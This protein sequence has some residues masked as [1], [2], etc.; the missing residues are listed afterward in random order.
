M[1]FK[2]ICDCGSEYVRW[3]HFSTSWSYGGKWKC[4]LCG[5][6]EIVYEE[7]QADMGD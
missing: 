5:Q 1:G 7:N 2:V 6:E 4:A 3:I